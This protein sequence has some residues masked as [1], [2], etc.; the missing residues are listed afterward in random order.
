MGTWDSGTRNC[1][2]GFGE[3]YGEGSFDEPLRLASF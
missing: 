3:V 1:S 2:I